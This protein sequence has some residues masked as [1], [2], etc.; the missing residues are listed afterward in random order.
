[1]KAIYT[2][3]QS[4]QIFT[5]WCMVLDSAL[6]TELTSTDWCMVLDSALYTVL[7]STDWYVK[8]IDRTL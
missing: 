4:E 2:M 8:V 1:M 7:T 6:Y 3:S 5:D